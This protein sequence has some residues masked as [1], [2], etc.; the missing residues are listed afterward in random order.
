MKGKA[1][2]SIRRDQFRNAAMKASRVKD[3][4]HLENVT[5]KMKIRLQDAFYVYSIKFQRV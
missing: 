4:T 1:V 2:I 5:V 3:K